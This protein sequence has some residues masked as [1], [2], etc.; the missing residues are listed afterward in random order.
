MFF[1]NCFI[2]VTMDTESL[3]LGFV[4]N[5]FPEYSKWDRVEI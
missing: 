1:I 4:S 2:I 5:Q 3:V